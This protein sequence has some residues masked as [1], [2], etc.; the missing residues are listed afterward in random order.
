MEPTQLP[1]KIT[2]I[3]PRQLRVTPG[4]YKWSLGLADLESVINNPITT[5]G[6]NTLFTAVAVLSRIDEGF[7]GH[8]Y[9]LEE[10][11]TPHGWDSTD[12]EPV[13]PVPMPEPHIPPHAPV[14][15]TLANKYTLVADVPW[16]ASSQGAI[17]KVH[18]SGDYSILAAG[19][20][21]VFADDQ[22]MKN[23]S[24]DNQHEGAWIN[25]EE[26]VVPP[27]PEPI[28]EPGPNN[29]IGPREN[30]VAPEP[31]PEPVVEVSLP[32]VFKPSEVPIG[33]SSDTEWK[34]SWR[35][36]NAGG[37]PDNYELLG[38]YR[39][40]EYGGKRSFVDLT[41]N[42]HINVV[43]TFTKNG[44]KFYRPRDY[45]K[46]V[47]FEWWY[48]VPVLN[49]D[50]QPIMRKVVELHQQSLYEIFLT[51]RDDIR[52]YLGHKKTMD[53]RVKNKEKK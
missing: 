13:V 46:D 18:D 28:P 30:S 41:K 40:L 7:E 10:E 43:G 20:Y 35:Q 27:E 45:H 16:Y 15:V 52:N 36:F 29:F 5:S 4:K 39:M 14:A 2:S 11:Q 44:V 37:T 25:P 49:D 12:C 19:E 50:N 34:S 23:L 53:V 38:D 17:E 9:Y 21:Y 47:A 3:N 24:P 33:N 31:V 26:N 42:R 48:G 6:D 32:E 22:G 8:T 1:Y 51:W